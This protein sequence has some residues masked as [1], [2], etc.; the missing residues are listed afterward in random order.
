[1][2]RTVQVAVSKQPH[3]HIGADSGQDF[4]LNQILA[5]QSCRFAM[6]ALPAMGQAKTSLRSFLR[7]FGRRGSDALP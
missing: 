5:G 6:I 3:G 2:Q 7:K 1:M 4:N